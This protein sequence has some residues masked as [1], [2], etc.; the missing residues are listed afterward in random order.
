MM[1]H[2]T[3]VLMAALLMNT[4]SYCSAENVYCVI[5]TATSCSSCPQNS[6]HCNTL[7]EYAQ[8]AALYFTSNT[9]MV[10]LPGHHALDINITVANVARLIMCGESSSGNRATIVCNGAVGLSF[11]SMVALKIAFTCCSRKNGTSSLGNSALLLQS[12]QYAE[13]VNCSFHDNIGTALVIKNTNITLAENSEFTH[14]H[15]ES[16]SCA[17]NALNSN[18]TFTGTTTFINNSAISLTEFAYGGA[19]YASYTLLNFNGTSNF[20]NNSAHYG[21]AIQTWAN[22]VLSFNGTNNFINNSA[23]LGSAIYTYGNSVL[24]FS[25]T[26]NF[27]NNSALF[28]GAISAGDHT[29]LS[30]NGIS[31]FT[32]NSAGY[33]GGTIYTGSITIH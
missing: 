18:L 19:I 28:G 32:S 12:T 4:L 10:F 17:I 24:S 30:F 9:T 27:I 15:C 14:N 3:L 22:T 33:G 16:H 6:T 11:T 29:L 20:I 7:T 8:E 21:G 26:N 5:P 31:N 13:L 25:G 1:F 2:S 23:F